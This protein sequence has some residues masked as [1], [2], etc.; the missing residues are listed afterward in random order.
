M[1]LAEVASRLVERIISAVDGVS[2]ESGEVLATNL[3]WGE[4][5]LPRARGWREAASGGLRRSLA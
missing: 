1:P 4:S 2:Q 5:V 3:I